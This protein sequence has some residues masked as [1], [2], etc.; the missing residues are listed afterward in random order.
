[1]GGKTDRG[2]KNLGRSEIERE[3]YLARPVKHIT[4]PPIP[5]ISSSF[6]PCYA[7]EVTRFE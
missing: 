7:E 4:R 5:T 6:P 3:S 2:K 1:M